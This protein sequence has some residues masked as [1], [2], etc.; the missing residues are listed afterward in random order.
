MYSYAHTVY[1]CG[2]MIHLCVK[3]IVYDADAV[4]RRS[5]TVSG[6]SVVTVVSDRCGHGD[7]SARPT[8]PFEMSLQHN[9]RAQ[10]QLTPNYWLQK[11]VENVNHDHEG[12]IGPYEIDQSK[13]EKP[14]KEMNYEMN[15]K[16][17][18]RVRGYGQS[19]RMLVQDV[20]AKM[21]VDYP[22]DS[23]AVVLL[24]PPAAEVE[25]RAKGKSRTASVVTGACK[26]TH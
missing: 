3:Q 26:K 20:P 21:R 9:Q 25:K 7:F 5:R 15:I 1:T 14:V 4:G 23:I 17:Y 8:R 2:C 11:F 18:L 6:K 24:Q 13:K 16:Y 10:L 22:K 12:W 19:F